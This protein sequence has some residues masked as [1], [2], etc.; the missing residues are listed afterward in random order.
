MS[1]STIDN[2]ATTPEIA[3]D[4]IVSE[5]RARIMEAPERLEGNEESRLHAEA[6]L[7]NTFEIGLDGNLVGG[8]GQELQLARALA[9][10]TFVVRYAHAEY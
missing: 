1:S 6:T 7:S 4:P 5:L 8:F 2:T 3:L 9:M 10:D